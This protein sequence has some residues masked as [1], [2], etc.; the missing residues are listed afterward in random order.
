MYAAILTTLIQLVQDVTVLNKVWKYEVL[1]SVPNPFTDG[2][3]SVTNLFQPQ[4]ATS[5]SF[6]RNCV[7]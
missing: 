4:S 2:L 3:L 6:M 7:F 1:L 5:I